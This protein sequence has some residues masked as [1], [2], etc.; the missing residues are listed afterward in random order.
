MVMEVQTPQT[1]KPIRPKKT[2][3]SIVENF[4]AE[5]PK[6]ISYLQA[7]PNVGIIIIILCQL[8]ILVVV[9]AN[10]RIFFP[11]PQGLSHPYTE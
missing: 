1:N 9:F 7:H 4:T 5:K 3:K 2:E 8:A 10:R 6:K 11:K